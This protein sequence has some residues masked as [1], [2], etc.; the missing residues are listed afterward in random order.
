MRYALY[1]ANGRIVQIGEAADIAQLAAL[2]TDGRAVIGLSE[3]DDL[4]I[5]DTTHYID[6]GQVVDMPPRPSDTAVFDYALKAW[7]EP[8]TPEEL[9]QQKRAAANIDRFTFCTRCHE[10]GIISASD[11]LALGHGQIPPATRLILDAMD[12]AASFDAELRW[13]SMTTVGR[14]DPLII[15][16]M[17][18]TGHSDVMLDHLFDI[19]P[20]QPP[21]VT[22]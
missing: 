22:P 17:A 14:L 15:A 2:E 9:V 19:L 11:A 12:P 6:L 18:Q 13:A 7:T 3:I 5:A 10:Q 21:E 8:F 16:T 20:Y 1:E 4:D